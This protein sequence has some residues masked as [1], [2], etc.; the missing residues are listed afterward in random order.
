M[1]VDLTG[2]S[3][4]Q[5]YFTMTQTLLPRPIAWVI[6]EHG[7]GELNLAPFSYFNGV[8]SD[9]PLLMLSIG[10]KKDGSPKDTRANIAERSDFVVHIP[11][12]EMLQG[13]NDSAASLE[14]GVS[15]IA[16]LGLETV[17]FP[18]SRL[19]RLAACRVAYACERHEIHEIGAAPMAMILGRVKAV[20]I[21]DAIAERD[22]KGRLK[23]HADKFDPAGRLGGE[24]YVGFGEMIRV[25]R[26]G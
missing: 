6:S 1:I 4:N 9:P 5:V 11:H 26:P 8:C 14:P 13:V 10:M 21:D 7:N 18:G 22:A 3:R 20:Y 19:P 25:K 24:E 23:V 16:E 17:D 2:L 12:R 15:E